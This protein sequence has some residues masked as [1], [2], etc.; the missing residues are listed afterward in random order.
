MLKVTIN[1][2]EQDLPESTPMAEVIDKMYVGIATAVKDG[3]NAQLDRA[4]IRNLN[5]LQLMCRHNDIDAI[6]ELS[7]SFKISLK[8]V[9]RRS[10]PSNPNP[11][12]TAELSKE[13][14]KENG[15]NIS[16]S[17][18]EHF[19]LNWYATFSSVFQQSRPAGPPSSLSCASQYSNGESDNSLGSNHTRRRYWNLTCN[20]HD[21]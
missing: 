4:D 10:K 9:V 3:Y 13:L 11:G 16:G 20:D 17:S 19:L 18:L 2:E 14:A 15:Q 8:E 12:K 21:E 5:D 7:L 6:S 1:G